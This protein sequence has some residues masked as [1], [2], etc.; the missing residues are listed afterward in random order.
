MTL[1]YLIDPFSGDTK[2]KKIKAR[3]TTEHSASSYGQPVIVLEDGGAIDLMSWV[4]CNYQVVR[5]TKKERESLVSI[6]LL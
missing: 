4:G 5:A 3:I 2:R 1:S 6:G